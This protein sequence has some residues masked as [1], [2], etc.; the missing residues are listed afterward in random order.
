MK[1]INLFGGPGVGK[2]TTGLVLAGLLKIEGFEAEYVPEFAKFAVWSDNQAALSDQIYMFAKQENRLHV[3]RDAGL[4]FVITDGPL[5]QALLY[6]PPGYFASYRQ[7]V[8][9][10]FKSYQNI[11]F[12]LE[13]N[14]ALPYQQL[15]RL[16]SEEEAQ[17][18]C[19]KVL[20][21]CEEAG[22]ELDRRHVSPSL[23]QELLSHLK[24]TT[25]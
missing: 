3:L 18:L 21:L 13:R 24:G 8:L 1:V 22:I 4:D 10:V 20:A 14:P 9:D 5:P 12:F 16:Q 23:P 17:T 11:N 7:L 2:S 6:C 19:D 25:S 15:G